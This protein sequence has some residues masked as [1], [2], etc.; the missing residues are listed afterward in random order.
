MNATKI[1]QKKT[2]KT[3]SQSQAVRDDILSVYGEV[4]G[5]RKVVEE[6]QKNQA[7]QISVQNTFMTRTDER[8]CDINSRLDEQGSSQI[9]A[10]L[11]RMEE[12]IA[13]LGSALDK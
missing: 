10:S 13:G 4:V 9:F 11:A 2:L 6:V 7:D 12:G 1:R 8:F 5:V 3:R